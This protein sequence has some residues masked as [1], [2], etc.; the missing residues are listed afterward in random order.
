[1][2]KTFHAHFMVK[3]LITLKLMPKC[4]KM[5]LK[6][7]LLAFLQSQFIV[8]LQEHEYS[9]YCVLVFFGNPFLLI[10]RQKEIKCSFCLFLYFLHEGKEVL[11]SVFC[12]KCLFMLEIQEKWLKKKLYGPFLWMGFNCLKARA[13][14]RRQG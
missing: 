10:M 2:E 4:A 14:P 5:G 7:V 12:Q 11:Y 13:T 6:M 8:C 9:K 3:I 1:M